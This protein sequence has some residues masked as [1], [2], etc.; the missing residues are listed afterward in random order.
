MR[1]SACWE[2]GCHGEGCVEEWADRAR[3]LESLW[4]DRMT[5]GAGQRSRRYDEHTAN[6]CQLRYWQ[7][8]DHFA[9]TRHMRSGE[10]L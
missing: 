9:Q 3:L 5:D 4:Y 7:R 8:Y 10:H 6:P 1:R 2:C